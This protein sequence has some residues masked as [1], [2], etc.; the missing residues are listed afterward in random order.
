MGDGSQSLKAAIDK[1]AAAG[2][3]QER[4][5]RGG[6]TNGEDEGSSAISFFNS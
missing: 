3:A 2:V 4:D 5:H 1:P 6:V